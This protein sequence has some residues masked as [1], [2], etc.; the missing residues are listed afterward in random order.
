MNNNQI[1]FSVSI[2][3]IA[4]SFIG[5]GLLLKRNPPK[6]INYFYGYRSKNAMKN[7]EQWDFAQKKSSSELIRFGILQCLNFLL[8]IIIPEDISYAPYVI[9]IIV[10][11][12]LLNY[13]LIIS[14]IE[15]AIKKEFRNK[16]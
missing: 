3:I 7:P 6:R 14:R 8:L 5:T 1:L 12:I 4:I 15:K 13:F 16:T 9:G 2:F 11:L 10:F